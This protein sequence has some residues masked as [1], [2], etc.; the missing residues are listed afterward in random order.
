MFEE[1]SIREQKFNNV[2][3]ICYKMNSFTHHFSCRGSL[4]S[5]CH[6]ACC[7]EADACCTRSVCLE[8]PEQ[9]KH[10]LESHGLFVCGAPKSFFDCHC[11]CMGF[12]TQQLKG[13]VPVLFIL[14]VYFCGNKL[15][16][17]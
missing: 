14:C 4:I 6:I 5:L 8:N 11:L 2:M 12:C 17:V 13:I 16:D 3:A 1:C 7:L 15:E 10:K 9:Q